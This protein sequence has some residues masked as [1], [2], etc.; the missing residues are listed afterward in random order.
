MTVRVEKLS[1][2]DG[3]KAIACMMVFNFHFINA[4]Y[5]GIYS[6]NP[7]DFK[8]DSLEYIIGSTPLNLVVGGKV[9]T[10]MFMVLSGFLVAYRFFKTKDTKSLGTSSFKKYFRLVL[11]ILV[12]NVFVAL[13]MYFDFF[14]NAQASIIAKTQ[15]FFGNYNQFSPSILQAVKE[16]VWGCFIG[17]SNQYNGPIWFIQYEFIG[18]IM[19]AALLALFGK[20]KARYVVYL[21]AG[22]V[23]IRSD[24]LAFLLGVM[25]CDATYSGEIFVERIKK[26][27]WMLWMFFVAGLFLC[28]FP[29]IGDRMDGTI[30]Q[31]F[32]LKIMLYYM[33]GCAMVLFAVLHLLP[34]QKILSW[35]GFRW[36][37]RYSYCF[38][39]LHFVVLCTFSSN[40]FLALEDKMNYHMLAIL[41]YILTF[42]LTMVLAY[43][44]HLFVEKPGIA[45]A[46]KIT[47]KLMK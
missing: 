37:N 33:V 9:G 40:M 14:Q 7:T 47:N 30:Y 41:N 29:P 35:R 44:L 38:Y 42:I 8:L 36:F 4:F 27:K 34:I 16:A 43:L 3:L 22:I 5:C 18:S 2:M 32:P 19:M 11:P 10:R 45:G 25:V 26:Q 39:L 31:F 15:V 12:V 17:G 6:L 28:S 46:E 1:F 13:L 24:Y 23:W 20:T 21:V